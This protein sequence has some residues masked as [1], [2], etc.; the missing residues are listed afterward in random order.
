MA[1]SLSRAFFV[2][3]PRTTHNHKGKRIGIIS[4]Q[5]LSASQTLKK[6]SNNWWTSHEI[7]KW[8]AL[9][10]NWD[11]KLTKCFRF[12]S[13][14]CCYSCVL[15]LIVL[16]YIFEKTTTGMFPRQSRK[17]Q[18][19]YSYALRV[20]INPAS[21]QL[22]RI[23]S[24]EWIVRR[25]SCSL[26]SKAKHKTRRRTRIL[27]QTELVLCFVKTE[28][29]SI[30]II[31]MITL[32]RGSRASHSKHEK[33]VH[34]YWFAIR[35]AP[36][37]SAQHMTIVRFSISFLFLFCISIYND[38]HRWVHLERYQQSKQ[39]KVNQND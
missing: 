9:F 3:T 23:N 32:C 38:T 27:V 35:T 10:R 20:D 30:W 12:F 7:I 4:L 2:R 25:C 15:R 36:L 5:F 13:H 1:P 8:F 34:L 19:Y 18:V 29:L 24:R 14:K 39:L 22:A 31:I 11:S 17:I 16:K 6:Y 26:S 37:Y 28:A 33:D 21:L